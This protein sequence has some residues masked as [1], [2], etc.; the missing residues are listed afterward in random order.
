MRSELLSVK[1]LEKGY[2]ERKVVNAI[3][4]S[5]LNGEI[6]GFLGPNGAGFWYTKPRIPVFN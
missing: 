2:G 5:I 3:S 4:F 1:D 6:L